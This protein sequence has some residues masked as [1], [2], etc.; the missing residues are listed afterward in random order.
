[1]FLPQPAQFN[2]PAIL[3]VAGLVACA[4]LP[5][6]A[7]AH[8]NAQTRPCDFA[9]TETARVDERPLIPS[10]LASEKCA[11]IQYPSVSRSRRGAEITPVSAGD[12]ANSSKCS[13]DAATFDF[14][15][16]SDGARRVHASFYTDNAADRD[17][18]DHL[19]ALTRKDSPYLALGIEEQFCGDTRKFD[20][21]L[22]AIDV[23]KIDRCALT[24]A[25]E[26]RLWLTLASFL[27]FIKFVRS[28]TDQGTVS[29]TLLRRN[30][31]T[32]TSSLTN[33]P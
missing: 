14:F 25:P 30:H 8:G 13:A 20:E 11:P 19:L 18:A 1:M 7:A 24:S 9:I 15:L 26:P 10:A 3:A 12:F 16:L 33:I 6:R 32:D 21:L 28:W 22:L 27:V 29:A 31:P 4:V 2:R 17:C 23:R 5:G